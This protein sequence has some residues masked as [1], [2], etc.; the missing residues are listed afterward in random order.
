MFDLISVTRLKKRSKLCTTLHRKEQRNQSQLNSQ[1]HQL[2]LHRQL[3]NS[4]QRLLLR[5]CPLWPPIWVHNDDSEDRFIIM[6]LLA[7]GTSRFHRWHDMQ[8]AS[9]NLPSK[10]FWIALLF[11]QHVLHSTLIAVCFLITEAAI[12]SKLWLN[13]RKKVFGLHKDRNWFYSMK[14][15]KQFQKINMVLC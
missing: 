9:I 3:I 1:I 12:F 5:A 4:L 11:Y 6:Q 13:G 14:R 8:P 2:R 10:P 15:N 7:S